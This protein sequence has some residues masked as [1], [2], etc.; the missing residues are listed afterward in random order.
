MSTITLST[1]LKP[2]LRGVLLGGAILAG[3]S[4]WNIEQAD[5]DSFVIP[6]AQPQIV[7]DEQG[8]L[9]EERD[10]LRD[11]SKQSD[12][13]VIAFLAETIVTLESTDWPSGYRGEFLQDIAP[14]ALISAH[15]YQIPPSIII[16][17][18]I[19]ESGWG[20][21]NLAANFNNLFGIKGSG[22]N[23]VKIRTFERNS[24]NRRYGKWAKFRVFENRKE[25]IFYHGRLL[26]KD[27]RYSTARA[28]RHD[29]HSF[30]ENASKYYASDPNYTKKLAVI[31]E[32]YQLDRWDRLIGFLDT[33]NLDL[34]R[35]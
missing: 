33:E 29:W 14:A 32:G 11:F 16:G 30:M 4:L 17:Q 9:M 28:Y 26:A 35:Q 12:P 31:I 21:S 13:D 6:Y 15:E 25:A 24:R 2:F 8:L 5:A 10:L 23:T 20:R 34:S 19:F 3:L 18:A 22:D 7:L 1:L 27:R